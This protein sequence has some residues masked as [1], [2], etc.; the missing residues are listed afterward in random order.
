MLQ[1]VIFAHLKREL[2]RIGEATEASE[3]KLSLKAKD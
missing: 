3:Q 2:H 1:G